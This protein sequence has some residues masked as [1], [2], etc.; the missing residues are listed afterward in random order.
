M[1]KVSL[2]KI[3]PIKDIDPMIITI[4]DTSVEVIQYLPITEKL[5]LVER[6]LNATVDTTGFFNPARLEI[7]T[8]LEIVKTYSNISIT[9]KMMENAAK[10]YDVLSMNNIIDMV[11]AA[12]PEEEY[13]MILDTVEECAKSTVSYLTSFAGMMKNVLDDYKN[14]KMNAEDIMNILDDPEQLTFLKDV[15]LKMG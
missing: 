3:T 10:T 14:T 13:V 4:N 11:I 5:E 1:A 8:N 6:V 15:M 2:S 7:F 12:I 9:D